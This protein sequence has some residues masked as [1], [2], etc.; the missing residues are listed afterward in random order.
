MTPAC[1]NCQFFKLI[2]TTAETKQ[3]GRCRRH[4]PKAGNNFP[5]LGANEWCGE[6]SIST[7][8]ETEEKQL[9][10]A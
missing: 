4:P 3:M 6:Y 7:S 5:I 8:L 1:S 2:K 9:D 10:D